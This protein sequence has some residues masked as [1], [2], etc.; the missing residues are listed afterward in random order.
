MSPPLVSICMPCFNAEFYVAAALDSALAQTWQPLEIIAVNDGSTD[1]TGEILE[2]YRDRG[3]KVIDQ[4]NA[5]AATAR[6]CA[7]L[8]S[9]GTHIL[10]LDADDLIS[11]NHVQALMAALPLGT[12]HIAMSQWDRF[13]GNPDEALFPH[14]PSYQSLPGGEWLTRDWM[15]GEPMNQSGMFLIPRDLIE[16]AGSWNPELC[17][18]DDFEFFARIISK[19]EGVCFTSEARLFYRSCLPDSL[20]GTRTRKSA[21]SACISLLLGTNHLL[22]IEDT[23][24]TRRASANVLQTFIYGFYPLFPDLRSRINRRIKELGG[25]DLQ[26]SG[27]PG[28]HK[29]RRWTGWRIAR[30][31][32]LLAEHWGMNLAARAASVDRVPR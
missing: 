1:M 17:L 13:A 12:Q 31:V 22:E 9:S 27:P 28:F 6:N 10:F 15:S 19:S 2:T 7:Y 11:P 25:S 21:E 26:P 18:I 32:Q 8:A 14:R 24:R 29:L 30:R 23:S 16:D 20:S 3:V 4:E 5:G